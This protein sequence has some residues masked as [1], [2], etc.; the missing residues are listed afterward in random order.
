MMQIRSFP[1]MALIVVSSLVLFPFSVYA[2]TDGQGAVILDGDLTFR[3]DHYDVSGDTGNAPYPFTGTHRYLDF[4]LELHRDASDYESWHLRLGGVANDSRYRSADRGAELERLRFAWE[5]GDAGTPFRFEA[6][7]IY[8]NFTNRT[9]QRAL[10]GFLLDL[11]PV[12]H[13]R[14]RRSIQLLWGLARG[15]WKDPFADRDQSLGLSLLEER[16]EDVRLSLNWVGNRREAT[17]RRPELYQQVFSIAFE[18]PLDVHRRHSL[19]SEYAWFRGDHEGDGTPGSGSDKKDSGLFLQLRGQ[20]NPFGYTWRFEE[21]GRDF[22]PAGAN[23]TQ[24][25][26]ALEGY[27]SWQLEKI[28]TLS[29]RLQRY[30]NSWESPNPLDSDIIG[31][32]L[33]GQVSPHDKLYMSLNA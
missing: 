18:K 29:L 24:N 6:G 33:N 1:L 4:N 32:G 15:D 26:R 19:E 22:R 23:I 5:K 3:G 17:V 30:R 28:R 27:L 20:M 11:Q 12:T 16:R 2:E 9:L 14:I 13:G 31:I 10:R 7:E 8:G 25:R 21:Y